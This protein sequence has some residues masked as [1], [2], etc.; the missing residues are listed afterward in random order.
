MGSVVEAHGLQS[1]GSVVVVHRHRSSM[2]CWILPD[3]RSNPCP[4]WPWKCPSPIIL[5]YWHH[6]HSWAGQPV[7]LT[8]HWRPCGSWP[9]LPSPSLPAPEPTLHSNTQLQHSASDSQEQEHLSLWFPPSSHLFTSHV[10]AN[11]WVLTPHNSCAELHL[12]PLKQKIGRMYL[13][14]F[15]LT[16]NRDFKWHM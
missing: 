12:L 4:L 11:S 6:K 5:P 10:E 15:V 14:T 1:T 13:L 2:V 3:Q 7:S 8:W 9:H 16:W